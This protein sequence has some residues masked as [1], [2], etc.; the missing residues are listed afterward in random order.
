MAADPPRLSFEDAVRAVAALLDDLPG[1]SMF[2]G[3]LAVIAHGYVR[4]TDDIDATVSGAGLTPERIVETA[5][6]HG[7]HPRIDDVAAFAR[8]TQ[9]LLL[10]HRASGVDVDLSLAWIPFEHEA[11][12][13]HQIVRFREMALR[14]SDATDLIVYKLVAGRAHDVEDARQLLIRHRSTI[15]RTR[16]RTV[17]AA[18][19]E[20]LDDG[21]SRVA[22]W[23]HVDDDSRSSVRS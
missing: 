9:V 5:A 18:F 4:T 19:D 7:I 15:D 10:V 20:L 3:G 1:A 12:A 8:R 21:R 17:L 11:L 22:L 16:V 13:R 23:Q 2:I 14:V 6:R